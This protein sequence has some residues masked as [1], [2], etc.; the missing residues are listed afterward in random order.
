MQFATTIRSSTPGVAII[1]AQDLTTGQTFGTSASVTFTGSGA[2][3]PPSIGPVDIVEVMAQHPL[4]ARY[5][6]G[7]SVPN[8]I[9]VRVDWKGTNPGRVDFT[10]NGTTYSEPVAVSG[11]SHTFDMGTQL[12]NGSNTLR[13]VA[14]NTAGQASNPQVF[15]PQSTPAPVWL[16][17]LRGSGSN[18]SAIVSNWKP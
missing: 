1:T 3:L 16:A 13:I 15:E 14:Y 8:K 2:T 11:A 17:G 7:I 6:A 9:D 12:R 18:V 5:L 4:N 10:L